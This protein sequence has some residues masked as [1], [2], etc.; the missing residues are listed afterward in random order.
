M[1]ATHR[2]IE[3]LPSLKLT[4]KALKN[5]WVGIRL[6]PFWGPA[7]LQGPCYF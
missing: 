3:S 7:D 1:P 6:F 4:T 5:E 2:I